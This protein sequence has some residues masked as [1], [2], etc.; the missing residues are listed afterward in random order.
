MKFGLIKS[1]I[2]KY[3][4]ESYKN[5]DLFKVNM[6]VF[7]ELVLSD[8]NIKKLFYLYDELSTNKGLN[9][10]YANEFLNQSQI[11]FENTI[12]KINPKKIKELDM[13]VGHI[14]TKNEYQVIDDYFSNDI[15]RLEHKIKGKNVILET[16]KK[17]KIVEDTDLVNVP[18][19]KMFKVASKT[20]ES[21]IETLSENDKKEVI[22]ILNEK[23]EKLKIEF[24]VIKENVIDRLQRMLDG[25]S[26]NEV[27]TTINE[28]IKKVETENF[29]KINYIKLKNLNKTI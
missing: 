24:E 27:K 17:D 23:D 26:D 19:D 5:K 18:I 25:E 15:L 21:Y 1:R 28:T 29:D 4:S 3:L 14:K 13:W 12:N 8:R 7:N 6:S 2:E 22:K 16:I 9:E 11:L 10:N 20:I